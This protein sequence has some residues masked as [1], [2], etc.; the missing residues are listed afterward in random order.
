MSLKTLENLINFTKNNDSYFFTVEK[1]EFFPGYTI[2]DQVSKRA[3]GFCV[4]KGSM[5]VTIEEKLLE[6][7]GNFYTISALVDCLNH[8][9]GFDK[10]SALR[11][12]DCI[13]KYIM[14]K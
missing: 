2:I 12:K 8:G 1:N 7:N 3:W 6:W 14:S 5:P 11:C 9:H 10:D 13:V 4:L